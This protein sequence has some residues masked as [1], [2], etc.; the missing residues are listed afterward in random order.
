MKYTLCLKNVHPL[1]FCDYLVNYRLIFI[2]FSN[3]V[4]EKICNQMAC[5]HFL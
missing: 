4:A 1:Y 5:I 3:A 2:I